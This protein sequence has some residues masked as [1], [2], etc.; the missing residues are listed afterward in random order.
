MNKSII[1]MF[2]I[3]ILS[4]SMTIVTQAQ[5]LHAII[6]ADT[7]DPKVGVYD[8]K[9]YIGMTIET[10][11]IAS[12]TG[13]HLKE[14]FY[15]DDF[16]SNANLVS[17]LENLK[18]SKNDVILFYYSGHGVRSAE[19]NSD[20]PQMC[21]GSHYEKDF[22][23]LQKVLSKLKNQPARLKIVIGDCCN[24]VGAGVTAKDYATKGVTI[25]TKAPV[26]TYTNLFMNHTGTIIASSSQKG[27]NS[28]TIDLKDGTPGG[29]IFTNVFLFVLQTI[30]SE[31]MDFDWNEIL[32]KQSK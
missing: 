16:C 30:V 28:I 14:Y 17:V 15:K 32:T 22:Y 6:F 18:T 7:N 4:T 27:E 13:M 20:Y 3:I 29:G 2:T 26:D 5:T 19:D 9:D 24:S 12:A 8:K 31:G 10:S 1:K 23:P 11:T 21:L 25:L